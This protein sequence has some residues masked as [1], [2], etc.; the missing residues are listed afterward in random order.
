MYNTNSTGGYPRMYF[1][2][3]GVQL[4]TFGYNSQEENEKGMSLFSLQPW[5]SNYNS[6]SVRIYHL[7][8]SS[9]NVKIDLIPVRFTNEN[10][11]TEGAMYDK[12]SNMLFRN[13]GTGMFVI[14]PDK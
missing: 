4:T 14:G 2:V 10:G 8:G 13:Q 5:E 9:G 3:D 12:I 1:E 6:S 11:E 7:F